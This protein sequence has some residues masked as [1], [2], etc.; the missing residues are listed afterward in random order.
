VTIQAGAASPVDVAKVIL[1][2]GM[3]PEEVFRLEL[4]NVDLRRKTIFNPWGKTDAARR[5]VLLDEDASAIMK[6][7]IDLAQQA[8]SRFAFWSP[9]GPGRAANTGRPIGSV[10]KAHDAA[11]E[12]AEIPH[13]RLYDLRHTFATR[14]AQAGVD[15]LTLAALLGHKSVQMTSRYVHPTDAHKAEAAKKLETYNAQLVAEMIQKR[16]GVPAIPTTVN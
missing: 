13:F 10:R 1:H 3:R 8:C 14:A 5:A 6:R 15:V 7:R 4:R 12:R 9:G 16:S 2:T 11:I